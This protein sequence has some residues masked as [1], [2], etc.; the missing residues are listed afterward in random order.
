M[1]KIICKREYDTEVATLVKRHSV[2]QFGDPEGYEESLYQ[3]PDG[4]LFLYVNGGPESIYKKENIKS[5]SKEKAEVWL[6]EHE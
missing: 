4:K 5:I 2:G 1:K 6:K 3:M